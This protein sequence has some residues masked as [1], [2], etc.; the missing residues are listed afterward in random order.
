MQLGSFQ[1]TNHIAFTIR[2][3]IETKLV[4]RHR[5]YNIDGIIGGDRRATG[6]RQCQLKLG[7][8]FGKIFDFT[9]CRELLKALDIEIV[10][11][12][13]GRRIERRFAGH[14]SVAHYSH[15]VSLL[16]GLDNV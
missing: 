14:I 6:S 12:N 16:Q 1:L 9:Q 5:L 15:P 3:L 8:E 2:F 11:K 4:R 10:E 7:V 13:L